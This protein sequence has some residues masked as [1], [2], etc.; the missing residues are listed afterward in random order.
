MPR[1]GGRCNLNNSQGCSPST[2][3]IGGAPSRVA[4]IRASLVNEPIVMNRLTSHLPAIAPRNLGHHAP[5]RCPRTG[6]TGSRRATRPATGDES[7]RRRCFVARHPQTVTLVIAASRNC[8]DRAAAAIRSPENSLAPERPISRR[9][10]DGI[11]PGIGAHSEPYTRSFTDE[12]VHSLQLWLGGSP[13][14]LTF[15]AATARGAGRRRGGFTVRRRVA[16]ILARVSRAWAVAG[17][18]PVRAGGLI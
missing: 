7:R 4:S 18:Q 6:C 2:R 12:A 8:P 17:A 11:T 5:G 3:P 13:W 15:R 14:S 1:P 10:G 9:L 16:V